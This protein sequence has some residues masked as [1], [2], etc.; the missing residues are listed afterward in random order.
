MV[1]V[2]LVNHNYGT[3]IRDAIESVLNQTTKDFELIIVDGASTDDSRKIIMSYVERFPEFITAVFKPTSGQAAAF[4][5]GFQLSKGEILAFLD[6]DDYFYQNKIQ[7][8][9]ELHKEYDFIGHAR[10]IITTSGNVLDVFAAMDDYESRPLLLKKYGYIYTYNLIASCISLK[11]ELAKKI[12][13]MPE[14]NYI[15]FA[16]CYVKVMAQY[17]S[18]LKYVNEAMTFYRLHEDQKTK[19]FDDNEALRDFID[20]LYQKVFEDINLT[21]EKQN[22]TLIPS[23]DAK[24]MKEAFAIANGEN[25]IREG[26]RYAIYGT[27][28]DSV[29]IFRLVTR[30]GGSFSYAVDSNPDKWGKQ[31]NGVKIVAPQQ[32]LKEILGVEKIII[33]SH[34]YCE[35]I[36]RSLMKM[37][38]LENI[39]FVY[40]KSIP[41]D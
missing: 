35:E 17:F 10:K 15:T 13:P 28:A 21:L 38:L 3:Y 8:I 16:D 4:N 37:G 20:G 11:R 36:K 1:S 18:N 31:W 14:G 30:L 2:I 34:Y 12:F 7:R 32:N 29:S 22:L 5:V 33:G 27:G 6:A 9:I 26:G 40:F 24:N 19:S 41:N 25:V 39:D 23:L